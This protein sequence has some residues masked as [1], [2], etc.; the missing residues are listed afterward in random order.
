MSPFLLLIIYLFLNIQ[1]SD[2]HSSSLRG[3]ICVLYCP[4][5]T[6]SSVARTLFT[7]G[8][9]C[10]LLQVT[11]KYRCT[12]IERTVASAKLQS[13]HPTVFLSSIDLCS[14]LCRDHARQNLP[15]C[16]SSSH[17]SGGTL[18]ESRAALVLPPSWCSEDHLP[19][20]GRQ[21]SSKS[22]PSLIPSS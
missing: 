5:L 10:I 1:Y 20:C 17:T 22:E 14:V 4:L 9:T 12:V 7:D 11:E 8:P 13:Q 2:R 18:P 15:D 19:Q 3:F 6:K 16:L 21:L